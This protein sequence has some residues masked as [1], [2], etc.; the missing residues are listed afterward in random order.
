MAEKANEEAVRRE[1]IAEEEEWENEDL[2]ELEEEPAGVFAGR[3]RY[4]LF[5]SGG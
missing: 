5:R 2:E 4:G 1:E 3:N